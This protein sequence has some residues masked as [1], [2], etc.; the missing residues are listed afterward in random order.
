MSVEPPPPELGPRSRRG[1]LLASGAVAV[2][3]YG[4]GDGDEPATD[5]VPNIARDSAVLGPVLDQEYAA[6]VAYRTIDAALTG[7]AARI[8]ARFRAQE[9]QHAERLVAAVERLG[10]TAPDPLPEDEYRRGFPDL[11]SADDAL[12]FAVDIE[13]T[14]IASYLAASAKLST[15]ALRAEIAAIVTAEAEQL[16]VLLLERGLPPLPE[17]FVGGDPLPL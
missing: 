9:E 10:Q 6:I 13:R 16:S 8:A 11:R 7:G 5:E 14:A 17:P 3:L 1:F 2:G 4:C 12:A 15:A